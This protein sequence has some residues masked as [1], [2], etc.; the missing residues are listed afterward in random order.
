MPAPPLTSSPV[1]HHAR[2][3]ARQTVALVVGAGLG[4]VAATMVRDYALLWMVLLPLGL[5]ALANR[6]GVRSAAGGFDLWRVPAGDL[7]AMTLGVLLAVPAALAALDGSVP[8]AAGLV[9]MLAVLGFGM[10]GHAGAIRDGATL[11]T[12]G[13]GRAARAADVALRGIRTTSG[14]TNVYLAAVGTLLA[15]PDAAAWLP[16]VA[17]VVTGGLHAVLEGRSQEATER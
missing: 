2:R 3:L 11:A 10:L 17:M 1:R 14:L 12:D 5:W 13:R 7:V 9:A 4:L 8:R 15:F 6:G 16:T